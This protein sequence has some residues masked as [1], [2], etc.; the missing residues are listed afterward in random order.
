MTENI[1]GNR[2]EELQDEKKEISCTA[3]HNSS[4]ADNR[5]YFSF[6]GI[7]KTDLFLNTASLTGENLAEEDTLDTENSGSSFR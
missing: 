7:W 2:N 1:W 3:D 4:S 5:E 6:W